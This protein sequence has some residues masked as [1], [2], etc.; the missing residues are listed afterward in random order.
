M[1]DGLLDGLKFAITP[2]DDDP[3][4]SD[5][6]YGISMK[7]TDG[8]KLTVGAQVSTFVGEKSTT[9]LFDKFLAVIGGH[10]VKLGLLNIVP[11]GLTVVPQ[12]AQAGVMLA[13]ETQK[14][15]TVSEC[16][17]MP[18]RLSQVVFQS[19][20]PA[21]FD[22][23]IDTTTEI[24]ILKAATIHDKKDD[25]YYKVSKSLRLKKY[26]VTKDEKRVAKEVV[27]AQED[28]VKLNKE[29]EK[30]EKQ[31]KILVGNTKKFIKQSKEIAKETK[32][33]QQESTGLNKKCTRLANSITIY[34]EEKNKVRR[35]HQDVIE[36]Y[37]M[38]MDTLTSI[39]NS[40]NRAIENLKEDLKSAQSAYLEWCEADGE[41][42]TN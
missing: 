22:F 34:R 21:K 41:K 29:V 18:E 26:N 25:R 6:T 37:R 40:R 38:N 20:L 1:Q 32:T 8:L 14:K 11:I 3:G 10:D 31:K 28:L 39:E 7:A 16:I 42:K 27:Q 36:E 5:G 9:N 30:L 24:T 23:S 15:M 35:K 13:E 19:L 2:T 33:I 4:K 17:K 12:I